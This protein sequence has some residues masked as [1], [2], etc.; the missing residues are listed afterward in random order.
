MSLV[1]NAFLT[2]AVRKGLAKRGFVDWAAT[3]RF[4]EE[5]IKALTCA[6]RAPMW[7]RGRCRAATC[8]SS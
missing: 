7:R 4:A 3:Q 2:G 8:R 6:P 5:I 1:E